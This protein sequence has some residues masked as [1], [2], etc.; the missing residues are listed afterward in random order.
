M[1]AWFSN[2]IDSV[3]RVLIP[4]GL[5]FALI[6][7]NYLFIQY[8]RRTFFANEYF[9][10]FQVIREGKADEYYTDMMARM[11]VAQLGNLQRPP[12]TSKC[13]I[14]RLLWAKLLTQKW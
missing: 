6:G 14:C 9:V 13:S 8:L 5:G 2:A 4:V 12:V 10:T 7:L 11:L 3:L 1:G